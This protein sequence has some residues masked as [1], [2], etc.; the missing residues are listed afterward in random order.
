[1]TAADIYSLAVI[2]FELLCNVH[3]TLGQ[4]GAG[5]GDREPMPAGETRR[6]RSVLSTLAPLTRAQ[7]R[8]LDRVLVRALATNP[9]ARCA[10]AE[11]FASDLGR[12]VDNRPLSWGT[13]SRAEQVWRW[14]RRQPLAAGLMVGGLLAVV[15]GGGLALW[16]AGIARNER[17][18]ALHQSARA[19]RIADFMTGLFSAA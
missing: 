15:V 14:S 3:P 18:Q 1:G 12:I 19:E 6:L 17:D 16:Q 10:S 5:I 8:D 2:L 13:T 7:L 4:E 9:A 11:Q